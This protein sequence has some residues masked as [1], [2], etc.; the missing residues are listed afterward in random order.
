MSTSRLFILDTTLRDGAQCRGVPLKVREKL[1]I[2]QRL[3]SLGVDVIEA[4]YPSAREEDF[5]AVW[6]IAREVQGPV[7]C[8]MASC[9]PSEIAHAA[10]ALKPAVGRARIHVFA[11]SSR[12]HREQTGHPERAVVAAAVEAVRRAKG[13]V[14]DV[15]FTPEDAVRTEPEFLQAICAAAIGAG[16]STINIAD[17]SGCALPEQFAGQVRLLY[18]AIPEVRAGKVVLSVHCH[19]DLGLAVANSLVGI[20]AGARQVECTINGMGERAGNAALE[21]IVL[22]VRTHGEYFGH[23]DCHVNTPHLVGCSKLVSRLTG[24]AVQ[25]NK[26]VVGDNAFSHSAGAHERAVLANPEVYQILEPA[27][28]GWNDPAE[29]LIGNNATASTVVPKEV[30]GPNRVFE[31]K[32]EEFGALHGSNSHARKRPAGFDGSNRR[33]IKSVCGRAAEAGSSAPHRENGMFA[34]AI[35]ELRDFDLFRC[36]GSGSY[37]EVWLARSVTGAFRAIKVIHRRSFSEDRPF[38]REFE[39]LRHFEPISR[40]H[41]GWV[42]ILHVGKNDA[43]GYFYYVMEAADDLQTG[44]EIDPASYAAKS[45][46]SLLAADE[47]LELGACIQLGIVLAEALGRLHRLGFVHRDVK[48]SNII[49]VNGGPKLADIGLVTRIGTGSTFLG[50]EGFIP[51]EGPGKPEADLFALGKLLYQAAT[52]EPPG[53]Y[54]GLPTSLEHRTDAPALMQ[55]LR[56]INRACEPNIRRRYRGAEQVISDLQKLKVN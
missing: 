23:L 53:N 10:A 43:A 55:L 28:V 41:A 27:S 46:G 21:E 6:N 48:P 26:A 11:R 38:E 33:R 47:R 24:V 12:I 1:V 34:G 14:E 29:A 52:G 40:S 17:T 56:V 54:P 37:G 30:H 8:A 31:N 51:P 32:A 22:A 13:F 42:S 15:E 39:G 49:F 25:P 45:L 3:A 5:A 20:R 44:A 9:D 36:I 4:G 16:A 50:T 7:I 19:N 35:A 18:E 2:A